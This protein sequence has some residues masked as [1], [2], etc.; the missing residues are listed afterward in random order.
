[1][2]VA[3]CGGPDGRSIV[4]YGL[5]DGRVGGQEYLLFLAPGRTCQSFEDIIPGIHFLLYIFGMI[6]EGQNVQY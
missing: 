4:K 1:M 6:F 3:E 2:R 5:A